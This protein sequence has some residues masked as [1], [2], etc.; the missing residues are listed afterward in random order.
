MTQKRPD[1]NAIDAALRLLLSREHLA[2]VAKMTA[3]G[4]SKRGAVR[5]LLSLGKLAYE[6][7]HPGANVLRH[8]P[9]ADIATV[10]IIERGTAP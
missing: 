2:V 10:T 7:D 1:R 6:D 5:R 4:Y 9:I 8:M 3:A